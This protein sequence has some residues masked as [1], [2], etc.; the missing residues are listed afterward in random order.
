MICRCCA[1][2]MSGETA[3]IGTPYH[4][5]TGYPD[6]YILTV[7]CPC[8]ATHGLRIWQSERAALE[9]AAELEAA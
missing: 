1:A 2:T 4:A 3:I 8:G 7:S 5:A 9:D 6:D